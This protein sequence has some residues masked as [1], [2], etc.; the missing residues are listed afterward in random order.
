[1]SQL[2]AG[3]TLAKVST[4]VPITQHLD[5]SLFQPAVA[6][7]IRLRVCRVARLRAV[8]FEVEFWF[9]NQ[10]AGVG[11]TGDRGTGLMAGRAVARAGVR[12]FR[13]VALFLAFGI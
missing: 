12:G 1:M 9:W 8:Q 2:P 5:A 10:P 4:S 11:I 6:L 3:N 7:R 13:T